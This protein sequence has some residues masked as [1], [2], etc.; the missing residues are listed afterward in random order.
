M[1]QRIFSIFPTIFFTLLSLVPQSAMAGVFDGFTKAGE[2]IFQTYIETVVGKIIFNLLG[3]LG[4]AFL[5][6]IA[7]GAVLWMTAQ[8]DEKKISSARGYLF[9]SILGLILVL[10]SYAIT[11]FV[12]D[13]LAGPTLR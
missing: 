13:A 2:G 7:Y 6:L 3:M 12:V 10:A 9:H 8:G 4:V 5:A 1:V 11:K